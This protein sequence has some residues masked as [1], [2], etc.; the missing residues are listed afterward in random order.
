MR[1]SA[2]AEREEMGVSQIS[3]TMCNLALTN[4]DANLFGCL[5][6][7]SGVP[8]KRLCVPTTVPYDLMYQ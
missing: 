6:G 8:I 2:E 7:Y 4:W 3:R 1:V 5:C